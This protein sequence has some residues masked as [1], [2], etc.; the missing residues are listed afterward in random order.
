MTKRPSM[1]LL[2][3]SERLYR[4]FLVL[5][6]K[7]F[8]QLY[9]QEMA[10]TFR[11]CCREALQQEHTYTFARFW[12]F[13]LYDLVITACTEHG[14]VWAT[15][16]KRLCGLEKEYTLMDSLLQLDVA[17]RTD[18]GCTRSSNEDSMTS[19]IPQDSQVRTKQGG[20]FVVADGLG[21][22][23]KGEVASKMAVDEVSAAYY[24][25]QSDDIVSSLAQAVKHANT[26]IYQAVGED[27]K[28]KMGTT[29]IATVVQGNTAYVANVGDSRAY[30]V[31]HGQAK[32]ISLDHSWVAEQVLAGALTK[33]EARTHPKRNE[34][35]RCLGIHA[36]VEVD[37]FTE[38]VQA[39]DIL[40]LCTDGL[41]RAC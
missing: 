26:L 2:A 37:V 11:D 12:S 31:R 30:L 15:A 13:V 38:A 33:E 14:R 22:H 5:Y 34:I 6:P 1:P 21:G 25:E 7:T 8:R 39:G 36:D 29:C 3:R 20:L 27:E 18:L 19:V 10:H 41:S 16:L 28:G 32:Q 9:G 17:L 24:Q 35:F 23:T 4:C 40:V